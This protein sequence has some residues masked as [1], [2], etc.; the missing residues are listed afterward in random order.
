M[1][2]AARS[3]RRRLERA[4]SAFGCGRY[5]YDLPQIWVDYDNRKRAFVE[6]MGAARR[7]Y[8]AAGLL[9]K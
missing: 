8:E 9:G 1:P 7:I 6:A 5:L 3:P 2:A 4:C